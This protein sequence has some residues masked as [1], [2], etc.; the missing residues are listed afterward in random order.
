MAVEG[1]VQDRPEVRI[2]RSDVGRRVSVRRLAGFADDNR[3]VF[4]DV[5][6][7]LASWDDRGLT[8]VPRT[9]GPVSFDERLLVAGKV[10]PLFPARRAPLPPAGPED[11]RRIADRGRPTVEREPLGEWTLRGPAGS[12]RCGGSALAL[13]DPGLPPAEALAAV[14]AWYAARGLPARLELGAAGPP[15]ELRAELDRLGATY[16]PVLFRVAPLAGLARAGAPAALREVRLARTADAA[17]LS[18]YRPAAGS[19]PVGEAALRAVDGGPSVW[20]ATVPGDGPGRPPRA[21]GRCVIDGPWAGF[22]ALEVAPAARRT[23]L[24]TA[25]LA[26]LAARAAEEGASGGYLEVE[27]GNTGAIALQDGLG[28]TTSHTYQYALLPQG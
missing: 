8:V 22:G 5:I 28:F 9:G 12:T 14:R 20:F 23:G 24:G 13:G 19:P 17:R 10:V 3:P 25:V 27:P 1:P 21:V 26:V 2:D 6:G 4:R 7:V 15:E 16:E 18:P 11:L